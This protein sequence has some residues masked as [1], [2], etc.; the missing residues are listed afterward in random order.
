ME[1]LKEGDGDKFTDMKEIEKKGITVEYMK[2]ALDGLAH[3]HGAWWLWLQKSDD[4]TKHEIC[5]LYKTLA[6]NK[7][8]W[9]MKWLVNMTMDVYLD[10]LEKREADPEMIEIVKS[11]KNSPNTVKN[12]LKGMHDFEESKFKT[13]IHW[14]LWTPQVMFSHHEDGSPKQVKILDYQTLSPGHPAT[15]IWRLVY[16]A[17]DSNFR[18][19]HL[20]DC[21]KSY[22][23]ILSG[24]MSTFVDVSY[25]VFKQEVDE[26]RFVSPLTDGLSPALTL[27]PKKRP[28]PIE[29][30]KKFIRE[31]KE[32]LSRPDKEDD[33]PDVK[34]MRRRVMD[35][36]KESVELGLFK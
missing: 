19:N 12:M 34:E 26:R 21:L 1:N 25:E 28:N 10:M 8:E 14:D 18:K 9:A 22:F 6:V 15:D 35:L 17:T 20:D 13:M 32:D 3:F 16:T 27:S 33:H 5:T 31:V 2:L 24:Y 4:E 23:T 11:Y 29:E 30:R 7:W 36:V